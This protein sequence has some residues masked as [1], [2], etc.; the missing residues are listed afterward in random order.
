MAFP[1][2]T[3]RASEEGEPSELAATSGRMLRCVFVCTHTLAH[4]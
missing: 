1:A 4:W 2:L 3:R